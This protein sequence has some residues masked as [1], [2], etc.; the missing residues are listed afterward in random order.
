VT[1]L[2]H[3]YSKLYPNAIA[4]IFGLIQT[5]VVYLPYAVTAMDLL[6][7]GPYGGAMAVSGLLVSQ[8]FYMLEWDSTGG[9]PTPK[10]NRWLAAPTWFKNLFRKEIAYPDTVANEKRVYGGATAPTG[11]G[12]GD[13]GRGANTATT[14]GHSW[15]KGHRL[16]DS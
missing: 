16:G 13:G 10:R 5:S 11:R 14:S 1:F 8:A 3:F 2:I 6:M 12:F 9:E 4:N 15:G 7:N